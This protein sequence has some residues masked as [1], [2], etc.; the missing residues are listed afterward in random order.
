[1][2][3]IS[4]PMVPVPATIQGSSKAEMNTKPSSVALTCTVII[5]RR[6]R[7]RIIIIT[8]QQ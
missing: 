6:R 3:R 5:I 1:L 8:Q 7:R 4:R 2:R